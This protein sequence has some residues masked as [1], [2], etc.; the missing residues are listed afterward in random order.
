MNRLGVLRFIFP[1]FCLHGGFFECY[2]IKLMCNYWMK[3]FRYVTSNCDTLFEKHK[4][5][6]NARRCIFYCT[7]SK[8]SSS[9][10]KFFILCCCILVSKC[11][12]IVLIKMNRNRGKYM[13]RHVKSA[14]SAGECSWTIPTEH[15]NNYFLFSFDLIFLLE[16]MQRDIS[17]NLTLKMFALLRTWIKPLIQQHRAL[18]FQKI[19]R[20]SFHWIREVCLH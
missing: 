2:Y 19:I 14:F 6:Q 16:T 3:F 8:S 17:L 11:N 10:I 15:F 7:K 5:H 4:F 13:L 1:Y 20:T 18:C 12:T 9:P